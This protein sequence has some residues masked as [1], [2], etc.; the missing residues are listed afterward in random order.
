MNVITKMTINDMLDFKLVPEQLAVTTTFSKFSQSMSTCGPIKY[1][2]STANSAKGTKALA[3]IGLVGSTNS[4]IIRGP[5]LTFSDSASSIT[6]KF[7]FTDDFDLGGV[8][9]F[10]VEA[11]LANYPEMDNIMLVSDIFLVDV[12]SDCFLSK[13]ISPSED[14]T[15]IYHV[16]DKSFIMERNYLSDEVSQ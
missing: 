4:N 7:G 11:T 9:E 10:K 13:M 2:V 3:E 12:T 15:T 14:L 1:W 5:P 8:H 6:L 16:F